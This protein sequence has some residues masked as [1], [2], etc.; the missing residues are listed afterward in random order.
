MDR[1]QLLAQAD[2]YDRQA[3]AAKSSVYNWDYRSEHG[4]SDPL[5]EGTISNLRAQARAL[6][7]AAGA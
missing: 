7:E 6:R 4:H 3:D 2:E 5:V 1:D